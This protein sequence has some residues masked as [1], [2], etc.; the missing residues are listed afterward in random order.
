VVE[1]VV[2]VVVFLLLYMIEN[3]SI[4]LNWFDIFLS[5]IYMNIASQS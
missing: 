5:I 3:V 2:E 4:V 1:V